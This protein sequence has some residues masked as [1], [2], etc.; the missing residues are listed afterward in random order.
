MRR[1]TLL[2]API[3]LRLTAWYVALGVAVAAAL[4]LAF[5]IGR[6]IFAGTDANIVVPDLTGLT[7]AQVLLQLHERGL[8]IGVE[9]SV[10]S[11]KVVNT[12]IAQNPAT[13][14]RV[15]KNTVVD[16]TYSSG[17][18]NVAVPTLVGLT[19][20][21]AVDAL[22]TAGL[23]TGAITQKSQAGAPAGTVIDSNPKTGTSVGKGSA[24][25][26][27]VS[28]GL[29][30]VPNVVGESQVQAKADLANAGFVPAVILA[31][32]DAVPAGTVISQKPDAGT[33]FG[34]NKTVTITVAVAP[35]L[36]PT[37]STTTSPT[38]TASP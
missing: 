3:R 31:V 4:A 28:S 17:L 35:T 12:A 26:L 16:V 6:G 29:V 18:G 5:F 30:Q 13:G 24:V 14:T 27:V 36:S 23:T 20:Q 15:V 25:S 9:N 10:T 33:S 11:D 22:V 32:T 8:S 37:P 7:H 38:T 1:P 21:Q 34:Q 2:R 19:Q